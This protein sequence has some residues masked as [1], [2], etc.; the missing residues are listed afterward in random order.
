[1]TSLVLCA[2]CATAWLPSII[3]FALEVFLGGVF[4]RV[5]T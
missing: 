1:M 5:G 2:T 4:W 3:T